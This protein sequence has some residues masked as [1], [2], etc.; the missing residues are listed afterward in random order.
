[1]LTGKVDTPER[2]LDSQARYHRLGTDPANDPILMKRGLVPGVEY[3]KIQVPVIATFSGSP[4][5]LLTLG[6]VRP[7]FR[8]FVGL[9]KNACGNKAEWVGLAGFGDE[10]TDVTIRGTDIWLLANKGHP[11]G[12]IL[13]TN[14]ESPS[15]KSAVEVVP[16]GPQVIESFARA[17]DS[18]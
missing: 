13:K 9:V 1:Q 2:Y 5:V 4:Y 8:I 16:Q 15:L 10:I 18:L 11:R 6:D 14:S 12:R 3:E 17:R 7:E